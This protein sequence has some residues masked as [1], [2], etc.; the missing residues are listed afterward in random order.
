MQY[1][2]CNQYRNTCCYTKEYCNTYCN[3]CNTAILATLDF[4]PSLST[5]TIYALSCS[6]LTN[7]IQGLCCGKNNWWGETFGC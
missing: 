6:Y 2:A 3:N 4:N 5:F 7:C 1:K